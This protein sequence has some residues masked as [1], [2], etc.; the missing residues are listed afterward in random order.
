MIATGN[1]TEAG[2]LA[3][4]VRLAAAPT[5]AVM[6]LLTGLPG[7]DQPAMMCGAQDT[8]LIGGMPAMYA[9]M[10][11]FSATSWLRL[12]NR[13]LSSTIPMKGISA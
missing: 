7:G 1:S 13:R 2:R 6:A 9:L 3:Y 4:Y 10:S 12:M 11:F 5:F 8:S